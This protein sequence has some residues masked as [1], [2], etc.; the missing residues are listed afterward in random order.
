[1]FGRNRKKNNKNERERDMKTMHDRT[2]T[3]ELTNFFNS[4][5]TTV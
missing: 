3:N 4:N 1:M 2:R 5:N